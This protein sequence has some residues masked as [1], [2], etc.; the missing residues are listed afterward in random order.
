MQVAGVARQ[1]LMPGVVGVYTSIKGMC[2]SSINR[3]LRSFGR[4]AKA[5]RSAPI[6]K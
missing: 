2:D 3:K 1:L 6:P 4:A 5:T